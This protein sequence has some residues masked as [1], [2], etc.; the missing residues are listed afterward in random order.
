MDTLSPTLNISALPFAG[1]DE[2]AFLRELPQIVEDLIDTSTPNEA[3]ELHLP[4]NSIG[5]LCARLLSHEGDTQEGGAISRLRYELETASCVAGTVL[6]R[7]SR[8]GAQLL[9]SAL[10]PTFL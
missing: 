2:Q 8:T 4:S 5:G 6:L 9:L 7:M 10:A 3:V 1:H